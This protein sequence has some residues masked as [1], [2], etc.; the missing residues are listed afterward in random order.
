MTARLPALE[1]TDY[2]GTRP[3]EECGRMDAR[4]KDAQWE[5]L[6]TVLDELIY[7]EIHT[8]PQ[9]V[10]PLTAAQVYTLHTLSP[11]FCFIQEDY[12]SVDAAHTSCYPCYFLN[13]SFLF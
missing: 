2:T 13:I 3:P 7:T 11:T 4:R 1:N 5:D 12:A 9:G 10:C 8:L 6:I